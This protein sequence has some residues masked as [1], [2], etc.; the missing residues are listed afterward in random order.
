MLPKDGVHMRVAKIIG[1][2]RGEDGKPL[3]H[4]H[5]RSFHNTRVYDVM[6]HDGSIEQFAANTIAENIYSQVDEEGYR[7]Q[8]IDSIIDHRKTGAALL[9][10]DVTAKTKTTKGWIMLV[11]WKDGTQFWKP[12]KDTKQS[13]PVDVAI[14]AKEN[15]LVEQPAFAWWVPYTIKKK[16]RIIGAVK[17]RVGLRI[18]KYG[19]QVP[20]TLQEAYELDNK[21]G[22]KL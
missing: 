22:N 5:E 12:L 10:S 14:Y 18:H 1:R 21:N 7:Y 16:D 2:S 17:A 13:N 4:Y 20:R 8:L 19:V 11:Q 3:G 6:F 9:T 15:G